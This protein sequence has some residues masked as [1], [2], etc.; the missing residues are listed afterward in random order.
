MFVPKPGRLVLRKR[1][2][3]NAPI[4]KDSGTLYDALT[5]LQRIGAFAS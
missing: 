3:I 1:F 5:I 2:A 4:N